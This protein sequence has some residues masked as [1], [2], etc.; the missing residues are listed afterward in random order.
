M[1]NGAQNPVP[2]PG[3]GSKSAKKHPAKYFGKEVGAEKKKGLEPGHKT[4]KKAAPKANPNHYHSCPKGVACYY[5]VAT[6]FKMASGV[7]HG[8]SKKKSSEGFGSFVVRL[9]NLGPPRADSKV[10][11]K[12]KTGEYHVVRMRIR[13][14]CHVVQKSTSY[15]SV[16]WRKFNK[17]ALRKFTRKVATATAYMYQRANG[18]VS[19]LSFSKGETKLGKKVKKALGN[20]FSTKVAT[21]GDLRK[22]GHS[23]PKKF[24]A[25]QLLWEK[26]MVH[27][28]GGIQVPT[29]G[30]HTMHKSAT[31]ENL[32]HYVER[33]DYADKRLLKVPSKL[34]MHSLKYAMELRE[35][36]ALRES[37]L[38]QAQFK[39]T[40]H[41]HVLKKKKSAQRVSIGEPNNPATMRKRKRTVRTPCTEIRRRIR[42]EECATSQ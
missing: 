31:D 22:K 40:P 20:A 13:S 27:A 21:G 34:S 19:H 36:K 30:I 14:V 4:V 35:S 16:T 8:S 5:K 15:D 10:S 17:K 38:I 37:N 9:T 18:H 3:F 32:L 26:E 12:F 25:K 42:Y 29:V 23:K 24:A 39:K 7:T 33:H 28:D 2:E 6:K 41:G 1:K 11:Q